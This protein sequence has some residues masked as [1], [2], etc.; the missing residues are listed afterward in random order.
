[1]P[2]SPRRRGLFCVPEEGVV[3]D[4]DGSRLV[5]ETAAVLERVAEHG[6]LMAPLLSV[7]QSL[8]ELG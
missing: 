7:E 2:E 8:P 5:F 3:A 1:M 4:G 6:D